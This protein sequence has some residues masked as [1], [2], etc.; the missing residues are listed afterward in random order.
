VLNVV[1]R[2]EVIGVRALTAAAV[3]QI[4]KSAVFT[5]YI[6]YDI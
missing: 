6:H 3:A 1:G 5:S 4:T 2:F